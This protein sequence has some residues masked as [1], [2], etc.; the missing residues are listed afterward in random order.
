MCLSLLLYSETVRLRLLSSMGGNHLK[1]AGLLPSSQSS[2]AVTDTAASQQSSIYGGVSDDYHN[3]RFLSQ[4]IP[5]LRRDVMEC[6]SF[7]KGVHDGLQLSSQFPPLDSCDYFPCNNVGIR[8]YCSSIPIAFHSFRGIRRSN[9][10]VELS[11]AQRETV[12]KSLDKV[13]GEGRGPSANVDG[14]TKGTGILGPATNCIPRT[15]KDI[16]VPLRFVSVFFY[17]RCPELDREDGAPPIEGATYLLL[18]V[19]TGDTTLCQRCLSAGAN[20]NNM[21]FLR[22][23]NPLKSDMSHGYSPVFMAVLAEQ[24]EILDMLCEAGGTIHVYDRWGRTPLHAAVA[25]NSAE[26]VQWLM[27][28]GAP[29]YLG[30]CLSILPVESAEEDY[31]PELAMPNPALTGYPKKPSVNYFLALVDESTQQQE[32]Q[33]QKKVTGSGSE[34]ALS[35]VEEALEKEPIKLCHCHSGRPKGFCGCVDDMFLRWSMDRIDAM[36]DP[37]D[38]DLFALSQKALKEPLR[39]FKDCK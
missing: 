3:S 31:F 34:S 17:Q 18:S 1:K 38:V 27:A 15:N 16:S 35:P 22:E 32:Q 11:P 36:W 5:I 12:Y 8:N 39:I 25:T 30:D 33:Q 23:E 6:I 26:M 28:K 13:L 24:V 7:S 9:G 37:P 4:R 14:N 20:P 2:P 10:P 21:W 19:L 29:R